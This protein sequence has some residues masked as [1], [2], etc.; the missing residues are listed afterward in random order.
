MSW[1][2]PLLLTLPY[3]LNIIHP[4]SPSDDIS[5]FI[6]FNY[7]DKKY[8]WL[9]PWRMC[10]YDRPLE[11]KPSSHNSHN[12]HNSL[13]SRNSHPSHAPIG[14]QQGL[15]IT[16][17]FNIFLADKLLLYIRIFFINVLQREFKVL[18]VMFEIAINE[19]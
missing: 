1:P 12:S 14:D 3:P 8:I 16:P 10:Q 19:K 11:P 13:R 2:R 9:Y 17:I 5:D 6:V 4:L 18:F 7:T 15:V